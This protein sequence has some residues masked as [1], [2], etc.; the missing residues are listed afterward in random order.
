MKQ[1][2]QDVIWG[3]KSIA[4]E[5]CVSEGVARALA[6]RPG[7]PIFKPPGSNRLCAFRQ[8]LRQWLRTKPQQARQVVNLR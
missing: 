8:E 5:I 6:K 7:T 3:A 4:R 2:P 1:A